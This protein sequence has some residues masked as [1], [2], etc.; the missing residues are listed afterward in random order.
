LDS[1]SVVKL[2]LIDGADVGSWVPSLWLTILGLHVEV[3]LSLLLLVVPVLGVEVCASKLNSHTVVELTL[4]N[5]IVVGSSLWLTILGLH[6][7]VLLGLL[8]FDVPVLRVE[9]CASKLDG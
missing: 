3:L 9:I 4:I 8:L 7:E 1:Q 2:T 5:S 6:V